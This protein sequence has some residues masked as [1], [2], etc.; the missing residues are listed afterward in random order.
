MPTKIILNAQKQ[1]KIIQGHPW[2][3]P[4]A[5]QKIIGKPD[6]G[7]WVEVFD[8][9]ENLIGGGFFN[10]HS[11][12]RVRMLA[13]QI[14]IKH[15][16]EVKSILTHRLERAISLRTTL[17]FP[18]ERSNCY[19]LCNSEADGLSGL[20]IDVL[21]DKIVVSS[22]AFWV[23]SKRQLILQI[24]KERFPES[25][26]LWFGQPKPL[27]Q[28]GFEHP[29]RDD[30][31]NIR[32]IAKE[33]GVLFEIGFENVQK[34]GIFIDQRENHHRLAQLCKD[35]KVLDLYTYHGGFALHAARHG[36][37]MVTAIDSS[38]A[39]IEHAKHNA[40]LNQVAQITWIVDDAKNHLEKA[41]DYDVVILDPPKLVPSKRHLNAAKNLYRF[42]HRQVFKHLR[43]GSILMTC[44]CS[45]ALS[46]QDFLH[47]VTQQALAEGKMIQILGVYGPAICHPVLP[48]FPE[49]NY[50]T[51][52]LLTVM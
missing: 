22:S 28:D 30:A 35:K 34:T 37:Q 36:A 7:D 32:T 27:K 29:H 21:N 10:P 3:F 4:Q 52:I 48:V 12:Y 19:R 8:H 2:V 23:E 14:E 31:T 9:Q 39:A 44:N 45:S 33:E 15:F 20:V 50:L 51:A 26:A 43:S 13:N 24:I 6:A 11:L 5:I 38:A 40:A 17:G 46:T 49:G 47:L 41:G 42:L 16:K 1:Q 25:Q 18:N